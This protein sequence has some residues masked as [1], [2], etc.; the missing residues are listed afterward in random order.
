MIFFVLSVWWRFF[1]ILLIVLGI[2]IVVL[3]WRIWC[4]V[5]IFGNVFFF[6]CLILRVWVVCCVRWLIVG[7]V[8]NWRIFVSSV[9][10]FVYI[11]VEWFYL[12]R[13]WRVCIYGF[14]FIKLFLVVILRIN[15]RFVWN[16]CDGNGKYFE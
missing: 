2:I 4:W 1:F 16:N 3:W 14:I 9:R 13:C 12:V 10:L 6:S 7:G 15:F 8:M 5:D 11:Y